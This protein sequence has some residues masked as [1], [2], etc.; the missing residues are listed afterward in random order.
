MQL[1]LKPFVSKP[2]LERACY[3]NSLPLQRE[4]HWGLFPHPERNVN[5]IGVYWGP[6]LHPELAFLIFYWTNDMI[7]SQHG[8]VGER[9]DPYN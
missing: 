1:D 8:T 4:F 7:K 2:Q 3:L 6:L 5:S 9:V